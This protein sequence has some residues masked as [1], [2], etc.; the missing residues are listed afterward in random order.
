[1]KPYGKTTRSRR[2]VPSNAPAL[3]ALANHPRRID[4]P[5]TFP[6]PSGGYIDLHN[7]RFREWYP[8]LEAAGITKRGPYTLR[9]SFATRSLHAGVPRKSVA[10]FMG[11]SPPVIDLHYGHLVRGWESAALDLLDAHAAAF[12]SRVRHTGEA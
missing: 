1:L 11:T 10:A 5:P 9:H 7:W 2:G 8:A 6:A 12:A 3:A 4:T